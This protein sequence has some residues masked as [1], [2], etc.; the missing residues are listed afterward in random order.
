MLNLG[1]ILISFYTRFYDI[2]QRIFTSVL[3]SS[4]RNL[5]DIDSECWVSVNVKE[6]L[7]S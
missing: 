4:M 6:I 2:Q 3:W 1:Y 7:K 5:W